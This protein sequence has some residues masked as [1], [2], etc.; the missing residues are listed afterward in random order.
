MRFNFA[1]L[2]LATTLL[3]SGTQAGTAPNIEGCPALS[4]RTTAAT[5]V[6]DLRPDDIKVVAALG[7]RYIY[8]KTGELESKSNILLVSWL[9]LLLK[10]FKVPLLLTSRA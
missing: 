7:D 3:I 9:D 1:T 2:A 5:K 6:T 8:L 4:P 10:V